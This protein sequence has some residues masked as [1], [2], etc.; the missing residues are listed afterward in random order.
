MPQNN[1]STPGARESNAGD[2]FHILWAARR[3]VQLL[4]PRS[5]LQRVVM[6]GVSQEDTSKIEE[7]LL[8]GVDLSEYYGGDKFETADR[9]EVSQ[10]KYSTKHPDKKWTA[11]RLCA[12]KSTNRNNSVIQRLANI[13]TGF[14]KD[15]KRE[16]ILKKLSIR[17]VSNQPVADDLSDFLQSV[18]SVLSSQFATESVQVG[19]LKNS[20]ESESDVAILKEIQRKAGLKSTEFT[21]FLRIFDL[22]HCGQN[23]RPLQRIELI[24]ELSPYVSHDPVATLR[25]L[26]ELGSISIWHLILLGD[27][28]SL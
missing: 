27:R 14:L 2:E 4:N 8:L 26:C 18:Q 3:A 25:S 12:S 21:D 7:G 17:L 23:S 24:L 10:L 5:G 22:N 20:L 28:K 13:Y 16:D 11:S 19:R 6:E 15:Y 9:I 1:S